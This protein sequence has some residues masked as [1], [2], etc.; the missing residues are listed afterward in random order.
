MNDWFGMIALEAFTWFALVGFGM[1]TFWFW[2]Q[3]F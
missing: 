2:L 3:I 1:F